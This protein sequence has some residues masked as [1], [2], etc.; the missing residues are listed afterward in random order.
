MYVSDNIHQ[1]PTSLPPNSAGFLASPL[2]PTV[3][4]F[5]SWSRFRNSLSSTTTRSAITCP[6]KWLLLG[7]FSSNS[8]CLCHVF[9]LVQVGTAGR[10]KRDH[11]KAVLVRCH[12]HEKPLAD[13]TS[14][15]IL[16]G[17][18]DPRLG[19]KCSTRTARISY[20]SF[21]QK[22]ILHLLT[23]KAAQENWHQS[24]RC[25]GS[26]KTKQMSVRYGDLFC[27]QRL[28]RLSC[29]PLGPSFV[30][31]AADWNWW[32]G[33]ASRPL[34]LKGLVLAASIA[35]QN[36]SSAKALSLPSYSKLPGDTL[37]L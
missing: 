12:S 32:K 1:L 15:W 7:G 30:C 17:H 10:R 26:I 36:M 29:I 37:P 23:I 2:V 4:R 27:Y 20:L 3:C 14:M 8:P 31:F 25:Q 34:N 24:K 35:S 22:I 6:G 19:I 18:T 13:S 11:D 16:M 5:D 9:L 33:H 28:C 21:Q